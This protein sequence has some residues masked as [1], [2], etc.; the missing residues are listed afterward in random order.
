MLW[1]HVH[2]KLNVLITA[3]WALRF[4]AGG[5]LCGERIELTIASPRAASR[6]KSQALP[7]T[8][9]EYSP[10]ATLIDVNKVML[11]LKI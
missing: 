10:F 7:L 2:F 1:L 4:K 8:V 6:D 5:A 9:L 11:N 3:G